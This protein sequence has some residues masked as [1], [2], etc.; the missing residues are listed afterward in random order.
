[1]AHKEAKWKGIFHVQ[2]MYVWAALLALTVVEVII[3]EPS[4]IGLTA[5]SRTATV[6][7][8]IFMALIKTILVAGYY[9]HLI[10]DRPAL[11]PIAATP[12]VFSTFLTIGLFPY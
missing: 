6:L 8:L 9:M 3:P 1:M 12:F 4:L 2:Y 5:M 11:I 7:S 10:G